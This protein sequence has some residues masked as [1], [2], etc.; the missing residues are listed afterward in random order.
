[1]AT[2]AFTLVNQTTSA[3]LARV[4]V[5]ELLDRFVFAALLILIVSVAVPYGTVEP[6]WISLYEASVFGLGVLWVIQRLLAKQWRFHFNTTFAAAG[7]LVAFAFVQ[8]LPLPTS[9]SAVASP[10]QWTT[11]SADPFETWLVGLKLLALLLSGVLLHQYISTHQRLSVVVK[12][13]IGVAVASALFGIVR[14]SAQQSDAGFVLPF[15]KRGSGFG[16]FVNKNHFAFLMELV[17]GL[18][19]G[20]IVGKAIRREQLPFY[21]SILAVLWISIV[22]TFSR[23]GLLTTCAQILFLVAIYWRSR[24]GR[25]RIFST[26]AIAL[27]MLVIVGVAAIWIGGDV[28]ITRIEALPNE[29]QSAANS[30]YAGVRRR[31]IWSATWQ[32]IKAHPVAGSGLGAYGVA[33]TQFHYASGELIPEAAH[34]D[35]LEL[36]ASAGLMGAGLV[37]WFAVSL[38]TQVRRQFATRNT[39][40]RAACLGALAGIFG[41]LIHSVVDF[42]L[43]VTANALVAVTLVVIATKDFVKEEK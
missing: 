2:A 26:A 4:R 29:V 34:N 21:L 23:G 28:L 35:Y 40:Q 9:L 41:I 14:A 27:V 39:F 18:I 24:N 16:Q 33:I 11:V 15:L 20:L 42:G 10:H 36:L 3:K 13:L 38:F 31:E 37:V 7:L 5:A 1:M 19:G 30:A 12:V 25:F 8:T 22:M 17:A 32:L 43:H 6:W